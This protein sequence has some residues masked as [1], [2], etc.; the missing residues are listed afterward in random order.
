MAS[1]HLAAVYNFIDEIYL[2]CTSYSWMATVKIVVANQANN[3][4]QYKNTKRKVLNCNVNIF[5][6]KRFLK[7][8]ISKYV[9]K[10]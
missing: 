1:Q 2:S 5:A 7:A 3:V 4:Y 8:V 9:K 10:N 6:M